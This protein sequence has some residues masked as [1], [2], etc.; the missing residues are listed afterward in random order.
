VCQLAISKNIDTLPVLF[1]VPG[2]MENSDT[3]GNGENL[4]G[5]VEKFLGA[6][7]CLLAD[8]GAPQDP[9]R[10]WTVIAAAASQRARSCE[11]REHDDSG[12]AQDP[13]LGEHTLRH[14]AL[15]QYMAQTDRVTLPA[16]PG[17]SAEVLSSLLQ[18][19]LRAAWPQGLEVPLLPGTIEECRL[20]I[21]RLFN[22]AGLEVV[23]RESRRGALF[24]LRY[25][26]TG[27]ECRC[28]SY[29]AMSRNRFRQ[30]S[31]SVNRVGDKAIPWVLLFARP[32]MK[33]YL[34]RMEEISGRFHVEPG[35]SL[36]STASV[37]IRDGSPDGDLFARRIHLL[38]RDLGAGE[39]EEN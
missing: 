5:S 20:M 31:F 32:Q 38:K 26:K 29:V 11:P 10:F 17:L 21:T 4:A 19:A 27:Q 2:K 6:L 18:N 13:C 25:P 8:L 39:K 33:I 28:M 14:P 34:R 37:S 23:R 36:P 3:N 12:G 7:E 15:Q 1:I 22:E 16:L 24:L 35:G 30:T 9:R